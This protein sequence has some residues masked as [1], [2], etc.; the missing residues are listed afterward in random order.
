ER[1]VLG[2]LGYQQNEAVLHT[3]ESVM[4][5]SRRAWA[6]WNYHLQSGRESVALT[7]DMN[8]LQGIDAPARFLVTLNNSDAIDPRKIIRRMV[9]EHPVIT[10]GSVAAQGRR[11]EISG[12]N[13]TYYCGAYWRNGFHE[14]GVVSALQALDEFAQEQH[15]V[16]SLRRA[17]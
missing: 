9:Y 14:D 6:S 3:D 1:S 8:R 5:L 4:P 16:S 13:R 7:Y 15:A 2:Q 17:S 11:D 10:P 12:H